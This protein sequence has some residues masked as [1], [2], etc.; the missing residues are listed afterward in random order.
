[1]VAGSSKT[2]PGNPDRRRVCLSIPAANARRFLP[3]PARVKRPASCKVIACA[4]SATDIPDNIDKAVRTNTANLNQLPK[5]RPFFRSTK[6]K[7][8]MRILT[9]R[10]MRQQGDLFRPVQASYKSTHRYIDLIANA[11]AINHDLRRIL[12]Y[13]GSGDT[14][15]HAGLSYCINK[16]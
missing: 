14:T 2:A 13:E 15:Y 1:M 11:L 7:Q 4:K 9:N 8:D 5:R 10:Q 12:F 16:Q 6:A 3:I